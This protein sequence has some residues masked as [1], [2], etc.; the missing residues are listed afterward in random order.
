MHVLQRFFLQRECHDLA[1]LPPPAGNVNVRAGRV[2]RLVGLH[3]RKAVQRSA[4]RRIRSG[5]RGAPAREKQQAI[6]R[7]R[8]D[9]RVCIEAE[10]C[11]G[12]QRACR[13]RWR[14]CRV[15]SACVTAPRHVQ[16]GR[17]HCV[18]ARRT[19]DDENLIVVREQDRVVAA[20]RRQ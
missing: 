4:L 10:G 19:A 1:G 15:E 6:I 13:H 2:V 18:A 11:R 7:S 3:G 16:F 12:R 5:V 8:A 20:A 17:L 14:R 9:R